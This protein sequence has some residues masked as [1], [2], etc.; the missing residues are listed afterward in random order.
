MRW[1]QSSSARVL[2]S[3]DCGRDDGVSCLTF[4]K[5]WRESRGPVGVFRL[6][7]PEIRPRLS[8]LLIPLLENLRPFARNAHGVAIC[9]FAKELDAPYPP[10]VALESDY[11]HRSADRQLLGFRSSQYL[12]GAAFST[13]RWRS[14][15]SKSHDLCG[16]QSLE[17][18][19]SLPSLSTCE[20]DWARCYISANAGGRRLNLSVLFSRR[21]G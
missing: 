14:H 20:R 8:F 11:I 9:S 17:R 15:W 5:L 16:T 4:N 18:S 19:R 7:D 1:L 6:G 13:A 2:L 12:L 21:E 10:Q 3:N